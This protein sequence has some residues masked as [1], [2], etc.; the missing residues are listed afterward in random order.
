MAAAVHPLAQE[1]EVCRKLFRSLLTELELL[2]VDV[3]QPGV[4]ER[5]D[6]QSADHLLGGGG[7]HHQGGEH[8]Q[9][10][11]LQVV[12]DQIV[13]Y[14]GVL[15]QA[16]GPDYLN[17]QAVGGRGGA[18]L[19]PVLARRE[20]VLQAGQT[21]GAAHAAKVLVLQAG[22]VLQEAGTNVRRE[23]SVTHS[24]CLLAGLYLKRDGLLDVAE[25]F[26][27][28]GVAA[29]HVLVITD[30]NTSVGVRSANGPTLTCLQQVEGGQHPCEVA[31]VDDEEVRHL[32]GLDIHRGLDIHPVP[33]GEEGGLHSAQDVN[34]LQ[35]RKLLRV[36]RPVRHDVVQHVRYAAVVQVYQTLRRD[37]QIKH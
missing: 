16:E 13:M 9:K 23:G 15:P 8:R 24:D 7:E 19:G 21:E 32:P 28:G 31:V 25:Q 18:G 36:V 1:G 34:L 33:A 3:L 29:G 11:P 37:H 17:V 5:L 27:A 2:L 26:D 30:L 12:L 6:G 4:T 35:E 20:D 14:F 10:D 22:Q